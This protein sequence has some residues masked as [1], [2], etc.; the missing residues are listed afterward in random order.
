MPTLAI[1]AEFRGMVA[2]LLHSLSVHD[3]PFSHCDDL[4]EFGPAPVFT[5][6]G[7]EEGECEQR[8][9]VEPCRRGAAWLGMDLSSD[10]TGS[11]AALLESAG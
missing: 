4:A 9:Q 11:S 8:Q 2:R 3:V 6:Q 10:E 5:A 1:E 7:E